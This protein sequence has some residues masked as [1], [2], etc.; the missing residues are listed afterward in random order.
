[1]INIIRFIL[2]I[3]A[4][5][6]M[7]VFFGYKISIVAV[8]IMIYFEFTCIFFEGKFNIIARMI[9][10]ISKEIDHLKN[11]NLRLRIA[12]EELSVLNEIATAISSTLDLDHVIDMIVQKCVKH[13]K[14]DQGAIWLLEEQ[15]GETPLKTMVRKVDSAANHLPYRLDT[16][17]TGW[18]IKNQKP[19]IVQDLES[20]E[21]FQ[22]TKNSIS[23]EMP[24]LQKKIAVY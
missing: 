5:V 8:I 22:I 13:L 3:A 2:V 14:V 21:R 19:L 15:D 4:S 23:G 17:L 10:T 11:E 18:M 9:L 20:D 7:F 1:M 16:Q 6:L 12:V 24:V